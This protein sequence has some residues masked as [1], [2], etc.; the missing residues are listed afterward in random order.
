M[1]RSVYILA[2]LFVA[3][4]FCQALS[5]RQITD[6]KDVRRGNRDFKKENYKEAEID[7]R[8]ALVKD[9]TSFAA[10]YKDRKSV[11]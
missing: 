7:Y 5:A 6:R 11:V 1:K 4:F 3:V 8:K 9:S 10:N 2:C